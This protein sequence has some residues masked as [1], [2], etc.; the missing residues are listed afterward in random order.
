MIRRDH[1]ADDASGVG[2][3]GRDVVLERLDPLCVDAEDASADVASRRCI[4][5]KVESIVGSG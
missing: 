3:L 4:V 2:Q 1:S 5:D